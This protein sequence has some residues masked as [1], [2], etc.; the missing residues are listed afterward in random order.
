[1]AHEPIPETI[2]TQEARRLSCERLRQ[3]AANGHASAARRRNGHDHAPA[4]PAAEISWGPV[5]G[6]LAADCERQIAVL[7]GKIAELAAKSAENKSFSDADI[8]AFARGAAPWVRAEIADAV[9][10]LKAQP[11]LEDG[12]TEWICAEPNTNDNRSCDECGSC[13]PRMPSGPILLN[14]VWLSI[15]KR[16]E[17]FLCITCM[18]VRCRERL[19]RELGRNDLRGCDA[20]R[21]WSVVRRGRNG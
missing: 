7:K 21:S 1:M 19:G 12:G 3:Q 13:G 4:A 18:Q 9:R 14:S 6:Q 10:P 2:D 16:P 11:Q 15:A 5:I 17:E 8:A 20:N